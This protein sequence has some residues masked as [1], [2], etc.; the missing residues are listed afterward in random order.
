[1]PKQSSAKF[2]FRDAYAKLNKIISYFEGDEETF[3]ID[4]AILKFEEG[5]NIA[6]QIRIAL[7][8][9]ENRVKKIKLEYDSME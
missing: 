7:E 5:V 2:H 9:A 4:V 6:K 8:S 3:D 1:M